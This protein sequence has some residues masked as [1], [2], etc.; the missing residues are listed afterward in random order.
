MS[1]NIRRLSIPDEVWERGY[2]SLCWPSK[3]VISWRSNEV[4]WPLPKHRVYEIVLIEGIH[5]IFLRASAFC[6][7]EGEKSCTQ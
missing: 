4:R 3:K 7:D 1:T 5:H 2:V 6:P